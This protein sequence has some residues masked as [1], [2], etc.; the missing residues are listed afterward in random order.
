MIKINTIFGVLTILFSLIFNYALAQ[1]TFT[2]PANASNTRF[3]NDLPT[4]KHGIYVELLGTAALYSVN[5]D[6]VLNSKVAL[7]SG[8]GYT[9]GNKN[10]FLGQAVYIPVS[11][12]FLTP[13]S[14]NAHF[15]AGLGGT[16]IYGH[17]DKEA[18]IGMIAGFRGQN[19]LKSGMLFRTVLTPTY[20]FQ[21]ERLIYIYMGISIGYSF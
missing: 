20:Y 7:R 8:F 14:N 3:F 13:V 11:V 6:L 18:S 2:V 16:A 10:S 15:E 4:V 19:F 21:T 12:S 1:T 9:F 17:E 5:Y